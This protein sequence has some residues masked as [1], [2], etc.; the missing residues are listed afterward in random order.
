MS[1]QLPEKKESY[2]IMAR[3]LEQADGDEEK[4]AGIAMEMAGWRLEQIAALQAER[5]RVQERFLRAQFWADGQSQKLIEEIRRHTFILDKFYTDL[6]PAKGKTIQLP[7]GSIARRV[8]GV[9]TEKNE[10]AALQFIQVSLPEQFDEYLAPQQPK[11]RWKELREGVTYD[12]EG[13]AI[14][15]ATGEV[16]EAEIAYQSIDAIS[17][18]EI[19]ITEAIPVL[20]QIQ[21]ARPYTVQVQ[22]TDGEKESPWV[23]DDEGLFGEEDV[24]EEG[25]EAGGV[26][27]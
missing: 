4:A 1:E 6:P 10:E 24:D 8:L 18:E 16:M 17:G 23:P 13:R 20:K 3:A 11:V 5:A 21:P 25:G 14:W 15:K 19:P 9:K 27:G 12:S 22:P 26:F 2:S 7:E